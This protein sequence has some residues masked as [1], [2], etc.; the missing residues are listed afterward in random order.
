M[1]GG[2]SCTPAA[3]HIHVIA[4]PAMKILRL[5]CVLQKSGMSFGDDGI[6]VL[7]V[8]DSA[9]PTATFKSDATLV[10]SGGQVNQSF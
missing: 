3:R 10:L 5:N 9:A 4:A 8:T 7:T 6:A 2:R 1:E